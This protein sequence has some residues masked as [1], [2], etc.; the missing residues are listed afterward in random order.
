MDEVVNDDVIA[1]PKINVRKLDF[2]KFHIKTN[3]NSIK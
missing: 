2:Y 3:F 1:R